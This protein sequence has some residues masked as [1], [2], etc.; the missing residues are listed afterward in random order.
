MAA[1]G[2]KSADRALALALASGLTVEA[3][4]RQASVAPR[5]AYR[6]LADP[7]FRREVDALRADMVEQALGRLTEG[8][9]AATD[10]LRALLSARSESVRLAA[11]RSILEL[12]P[13]LREASELEQR[14]RDLEDRLDTP[15]DQPR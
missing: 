15:E 5:T 14:M 2:R 3:A 12:G 13:R 9:T 7:G 8:M 10:T 11:A 1:H 6:R 4:A